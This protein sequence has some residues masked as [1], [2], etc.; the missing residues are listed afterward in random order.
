MRNP[1]ELSRDLET[2]SCASRAYCSSGLSTI[3]IRTLGTI[4]PITR[5]SRFV[6]PTSSR[7][8]SSTILTRTAVMKMTA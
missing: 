1:E 2:G 7:A 6:V 8:G 5:R 4:H 3:R